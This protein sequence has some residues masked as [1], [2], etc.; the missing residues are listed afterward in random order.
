[1]K[2]F[3]INNFNRHFATPLTKGVFVELRQDAHNIQVQYMDKQTLLM[4]NSPTLPKREGMI[5]VV[6]AYTYIG[7]VGSADLTETGITNE[8]TKNLNKHWAILVERL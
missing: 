6:G 2:T 3:A 4:F 8:H 1:M 7:Q 5:Y